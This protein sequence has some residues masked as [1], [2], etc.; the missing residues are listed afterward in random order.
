MQTTV[1]LPDREILL[2]TMLWSSPPQLYSVRGDVF[3][4]AREWIAGVKQN[5]DLQPEVLISA[6]ARPF[7]GKELI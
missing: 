3:R 4:D 7:V 5:R 6:T 1:W 2:T